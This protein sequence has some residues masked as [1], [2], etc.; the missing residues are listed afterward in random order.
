ME[1]RQTGGNDPRTY[2]LAFP[3]RAGPRTCPVEVRSGRVS[4]RMAMK[5]HLWN[6]H[7]SDTVVILEEGKL[8]HPGCPLCDMLVP[9]KALNGRTDTQ[10]SA[11]GGGAKETEISGKGREG[12]H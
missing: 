1:M 5:V 6:W 9:W 4:T 2:I 10:H 8:P 3:T 12:S 11:T 7:I